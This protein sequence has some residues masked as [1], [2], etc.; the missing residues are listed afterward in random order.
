MNKRYLLTICLWAGILHGMPVAALQGGLA[1]QTTDASETLAGSATPAI[2]EDLSASDNA[3]AVSDA[4]METAD[5]QIA[6][7][8]VVEPPD[9]FAADPFA[10]LP[11]TRMRRRLEH[12]GISNTRF[13]KTADLALEIAVRTS[14]DRFFRRNCEFL[15]RVNRHLPFQALAA[16]LSVPEFLG[17]A[18]ELL[19][20][21]TRSIINISVEELQRDPA[22]R[23]ARLEHLL[24]MNSI[25]TDIATRQRKIVS[26]IK[27]LLA[28]LD[29]ISSQCVVAGQPASPLKA[30]G[31]E[32]RS[33]IS[34]DCQLWDGLLNQYEHHL[35]FTNSQLQYLNSSG[36]GISGVRQAVHMNL[37][38]R[39][40]LDFKI[41]LEKFYSK[42]SS[43][44]ARAEAW[45]K[46]LHEA[47]SG[48]APR[49]A[50]NGSKMK[51]GIFP[52][53]DIDSRV[54]PNFSAINE[55]EKIFSRL[56]ELRM[57]ESAKFNEL[58][59]ETA[60]EEIA[61]RA[62]MLVASLRPYL[63]GT[64]WPAVE[65]PEEKEEDP[66]ETAGAEQ[67]I[68]PATE[69]E[70]ETSET[71]AGALPHPAVPSVVTDDGSNEPEAARET[72]EAVSK[73]TSQE[74][75]ADK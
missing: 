9:P 3:D 69:S 23:A 39:S 62:S 57:L 20:R 29:L 63:D 54:K 71:P 15:A 35:N 16:T 49:P 42:V 11:L 50:L 56:A 52:E 27:A 8:T 38:L 40:L 60:G 26:N 21:A 55:L 24:K 46:G 59:E 43:G 30:A 73:N 36:N 47:L 67:S 44:P 53:R 33:I 61:G 64:D 25:A 74:P 75:W 72:L 5:Q 4:T 41:S 51:G 34:H 17:V 13:G 48:Y 65:I 7:A 28:E 14:R 32:M 18:N 58:P 31:K 2:T 37:L 66:S 10:D 22:T 68:T 6:S 1:S 12:L 45:Q 70:G 19:T